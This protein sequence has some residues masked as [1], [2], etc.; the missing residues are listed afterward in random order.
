MH[1]T[2]DWKYFFSGLNERL[3]VVAG[4]IIL[5]G[6]FLHHADISFFPYPCRR[7]ISIGKRGMCG[8]CELIFHQFEKRKGKKHRKY[9]CRLPASIDNILQPSLSP[10]RATS[11]Q[12][13]CIGLAAFF[14]LFFVNRVAFSFYCEILNAIWTPEPTKPPIIIGLTLSYIRIYSL[15]CVCTTRIR[16]HMNRTLF[17]VQFFFPFNSAFVCCVWLTLFLL[18]FP[19]VCC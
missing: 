17:S 18:L 12:P 15:S 6:W 13:K 9:L 10:L 14:L 8:S 2:H 11:V 19:I 16:M 5:Q 4:V 1:Q 7:T 3:A